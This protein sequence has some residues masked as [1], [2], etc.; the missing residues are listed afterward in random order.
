MEKGL[1]MLAA[2]V[3]QEPRNSDY[4]LHLAQALVAPGNRGDA[5]DTLIPRLKS[6]SEFANKRKARHP[7]GLEPSS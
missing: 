1:S 5:R 7:L 2:A 6:D 3:E 4:R